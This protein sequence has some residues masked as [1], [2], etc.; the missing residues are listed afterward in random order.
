MSDNKEQNAPER[1]WRTTNGYI[2][3]GPT[4]EPCVEYV[5]ADLLSR[6]SVVDDKRVTEIREQLEAL[7]HYKWPS[8]SAIEGSM[9]RD[10]SDDHD[11]C[12]WTGYTRPASEFIASAK[13][14][15]DYLLSL[16]QQPVQSGLI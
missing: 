8:Q 12:P 2:Y 15:I 9:I 11:L 10:Y 4:P 14:N 1:I 5:R 13:A 16:L 7:R 3:N 6:P